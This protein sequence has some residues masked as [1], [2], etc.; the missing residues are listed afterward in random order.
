V[1]G[2]AAAAVVAADAATGLDE[3]IARLDQADDYFRRQDG[4]VIFEF[5]D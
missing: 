5:E 1:L 3:A 4:D 2:A